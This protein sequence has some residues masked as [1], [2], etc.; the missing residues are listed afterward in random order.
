[1]LL[2]A[3]MKLLMIVTASIPVVIDVGITDVQKHVDDL[4]LLLL[5]IFSNHFSACF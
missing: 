1:M 4:F 5:L 2:L 3:V